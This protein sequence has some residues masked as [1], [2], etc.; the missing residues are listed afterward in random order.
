MQL[1]PKETMVS[2]PTLEY[3]KQGS[4]RVKSQLH[5][6][7]SILSSSFIQWRHGISGMVA[8][9]CIGEIILPHHWKN[10]V[11][12]RKLVYFQS[13][14]VALLLAIILGPKASFSQSDLFPWNKFF[15][16]MENGK[17]NEKKIIFWETH[18]HARINV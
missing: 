2:R 16:P 9:K 10:Y 4:G 14:K 1:K 3:G 5:S 17:G 12:A 8:Q 13:F 15:I 11:K 7:E 18:F 6:E